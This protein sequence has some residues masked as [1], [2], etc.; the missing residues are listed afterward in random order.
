MSACAIKRSGELFQA[1]FQHT[2]GGATRVGLCRVRVRTPGRPPAYSLRDLTSS[3]QDGSRKEGGRLSCSGVRIGLTFFWLH[4]PSF[5][6][7]GVQR[8]GGPVPR[9][10]LRGSLST[11][12]PSRTGTPPLS[13]SPRLQPPSNQFPGLDTQQGRQSAHTWGW[14]GRARPCSG[15]AGS[16][17][18]HRAS[19]PVPP[20]P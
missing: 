18:S 5:Y 15:R 2:D 7:M 20:A 19:D 6:K 4:V 3:L 16:C 10:L 12:A 1:C 8:Q 13:S 17:K 11:P 9:V 14:D